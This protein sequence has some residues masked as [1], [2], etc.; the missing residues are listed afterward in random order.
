MDFIGV[1]Y[2][3]ETQNILKHALLFIEYPQ[4]LFHFLLVGEIF[5]PTQ[6]LLLL[7]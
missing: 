6:A 7:N 2:S 1:K 5:K 4:A 3:T